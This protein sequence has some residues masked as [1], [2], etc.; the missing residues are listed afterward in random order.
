MIISY[1][2]APFVGGII[3]YITN[4]L[5][6][7]MLFRPHEEKHIFGIRVPLTPGVIPKEKDHIA[8][9][10]G[11]VISEKL[12]NPDVLKD[13][14]LSEE[15]VGKVHKAVES[16]IANQ[17]NNPETLAQF[18]INYL[19]EEELEG[20]TNN[21]KGNLTSQI[22]GKL[23]EQTLGDKVAQAAM[24]HVI[25]RLSDESNYEE[26]LNSLTGIPRM[27]G[28][29][30]LARALT[31]I[32]A[33][34]EDLLSKNINEILRNNGSEIVSNLVSDETDRL[35][36]TPIQRLLQSREEQLAKI[37]D[38]IVGLYHKSLTENL[39]RILKEIDISK[40]V[41]NRIRDMKMDEAE[42]LILQV[43]KRE[44]K[45]IVWLGAG[46]GFL[47]GFVNVIIQVL[48]H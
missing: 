41:S 22:Q 33:P 20:M 34:L 8:D 10:I 4:D 11:N 36:D 31:L 35:L 25:I 3:G 6:I 38:K 48:A 2:V 18:I 37:P 21:V 1:I 15:M 42:E 13:N 32:Q 28:R 19:T 26:L 23:A 30:L 5:A 47:M 43:M 44:L 29:R 39:P 45:A 24:Q 17:Q 16:F 12:M 40:V 7:R 14:L 46:L 27:I 9:S